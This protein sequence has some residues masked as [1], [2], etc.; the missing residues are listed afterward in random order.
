ML[1]AYNAGKWFLSAYVL[2]TTLEAPDHP[3]IKKLGDIKGLGK[4]SSAAI[5]L[6]KMRTNEHINLDDTQ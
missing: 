5:L 3:E 4:D 1:F 6:K 2:G